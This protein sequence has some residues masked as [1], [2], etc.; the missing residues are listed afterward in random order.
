MKKIEIVGLYE[1]TPLKVSW[2]MGYLFSGLQGL[3]VKNGPKLEILIT[4]EI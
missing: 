2:H 1:W 3:K 4:L